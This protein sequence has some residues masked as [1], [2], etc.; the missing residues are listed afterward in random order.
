[1]L[2]TCLG[3]RRDEL[4]EYLALARDAGIANIMALRGDPP[5][6]QTQFQNVAGGM[7][8]TNELVALIKS[9][10]PNF[11][12][13]VAGYPEKHPEAPNIDVDLANLQ[14]KVA[15]GGE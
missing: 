8:Y 5:A 10:F 4:R 2:F 11:G 1:H 13:G 14:R 12:I 9:E 6:G 3:V 15:A 7:K